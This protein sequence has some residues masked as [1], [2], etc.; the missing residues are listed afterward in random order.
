MCYQFLKILLIFL[1]AWNLFGF[2]LMNY[3][4]WMSMRKG[5]RIPERTLIVFALLYGS[6]GI[7][8]AV[9]GPTAH[10][11]RD[12]KFSLLVPFLF[13]LQSISVYLIVHF[14]VAT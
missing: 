1:L 4:K 2:L 3:D 6:L 8:L 9:I 13:L 5:W 7:W 11:K 12:L 14:G 10:K